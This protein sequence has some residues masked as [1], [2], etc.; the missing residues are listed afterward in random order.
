[1][2]ANVIP[3]VLDR[4]F[5]EKVRNFPEEI[6]NFDPTDNLYY[7]MH[8]LLGD[9]G[10][11]QLSL[12]QTTASTTQNL[13]GIEFSDLDDTVGNILNASRISSEQY[14]INAN[15]F[16]EQLQNNDWYLKALR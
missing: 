16:I 14:G 7:L 4:N 8:I 5:L 3:Y 1:M 6:Y 10:T 9:A 2:A 12:V 15:P 11:G 13:R